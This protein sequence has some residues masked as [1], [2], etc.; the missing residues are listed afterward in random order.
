MS[1]KN[2]WFGYMEAGEKSSP[3]LRDNRIDT[4]NP[5]TLYLFNLKRNEILEYRR[6]IIEP[7][8]RELNDKEQ[9]LSGELQSAYTEVRSHFTPRGGKVASIPAKGRSN[10]KPPVAAANDDVDDEK[11]IEVFEGGDDADW[12]EEEEA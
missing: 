9:S 7:K 1:D 6:D 8:L 2:Y 12:L 11:E 10:G 3:V 4:D 5:E